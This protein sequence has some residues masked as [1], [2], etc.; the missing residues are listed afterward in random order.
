MSSTSTPVKTIDLLD[1][2][3]HRLRVYQ[4]PEMA[5]HFADHPE[6][7]SAKIFNS[8]Q[9]K[10]TLEGL[11]MIEQEYNHS[12]Y[13]AI[14]D[15]WQGEYAD[16]ETIYYRGNSIS[17]REMFAKA[18]QLAKALAYMGI[19]KGDEIPCCVANV[20]ELV[21]L[22]LASNKL[23]A[24]VNFFGAHFDP[25]FIDRILTQ[26]SNKVFIATDDYYGQI[27]DAVNTKHF[28]YKILISLADSIPSNPETATGYEA[29]LDAYYRY[30]NKVMD[31]ASE[32]IQISTFDEALAMGDKFEGE[33]VDGNVLDTEWLITYTSGSTKIGFPKRMIHRNRSAITIGV[34]HD[35][36]LC[37][38]PAMK[39]LRTMA[40][41][42]TESNTDLIT[43]ISDALFQNWSVAPEPEY[44]R[45]KF[46][47][48]LLVDKPNVVTA[49]TT[50]FVEAAREYLING[51]YNDRK[52]DFMLSPLCVG[53]GCSAGEEKFINLFLK[54]SKA[55]SGVK[56]A[57]PIHFP[58]VTI[59]VGG[60]DTEHGGIYY[61]LWKGLYQ[62]LNKFK[63]KGEPYGLKPV[64]YAQV[65]VMRKNDDGS[66]SEVGYNEKGIIVANS[67]STMACYK[68]WEKVR[69]KIIT[70]DHGRDWV[71]CDVFGYLD[72]M[73]N[74]HI[75]DRADSLCTMENGKKVYPYTIADIA[76]EDAQNILTG[77][78][79]ETELNGK[80]M[81]VVNVEISPI[82]EKSNE[83][84][85][86]DLDSKFMERQP[87]LYDRIIYRYFDETYLF[88]ITGSGKRSMVDVA[89]QGYKHTFRI[90]D[91]KRVDIKG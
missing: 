73:G 90:I 30:E 21:Y 16:W 48:V 83:E 5:E 79:T 66:Y 85:M 25:V 50:F 58:Y 33:I 10:V 14:K 18:D 44:D 52:L 17:A 36:A 22:M 67:A 71:S 1:E 23:G 4:L 47:D 51:Q 68:S 26:A 89:K 63:L 49:T 37:G 78:V 2:E 24:K 53:E 55:G 7:P 75:K 41:I 74:V 69:D 28:D 19:E 43:S 80:T 65:A 77:V 11:K 39:G 81:F 60:G 6:L 20:P 32:D 46:L 70:D 57:G 76:Q 82:A 13:K 3:T 12:W 40:H 38:N 42:H 15:R 54:K 62:G 84:I 31:F 27:K 56:L 9:G 88:P 59:G 34:F 61:T 91:G 45:K 64:P 8:K 72:S 35:P 29:T 87:D 86:M